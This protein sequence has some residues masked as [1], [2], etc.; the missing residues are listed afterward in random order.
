V[1]KKADKTALDLN[2]ISEQP[3]SE[4][5]EPDSATRKEQQELDGQERLALLTGMV[6]DIA[7]RK[8]YSG[9]IFW[10]LAFWL[11]GIFILLLLQ[12]GSPYHW[13]SL[14][15]SVLIAAIS[16]TTINV[17]GIFIVVT[18]YLFPSGGQLPRSKK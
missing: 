17:I 14:S 4:P 12:G 15:D 8:K 1:A 3:A 18:R 10:L 6:Q 16:G 9:R 13:F 7:E 11:G 5:D 2:A